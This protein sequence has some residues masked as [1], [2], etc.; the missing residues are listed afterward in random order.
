MGRAGLWN[1]PAFVDASHWSAQSDRAGRMSAHA[2]GIELP[3]AVPAGVLSGAG[4]LSR[5]PLKARRGI[6][7]PQPPNSP[8]ARVSPIEVGWRLMDEGFATMQP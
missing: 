6:T 4:S 2:K 7:H 1:A 8:P 5:G 3:E